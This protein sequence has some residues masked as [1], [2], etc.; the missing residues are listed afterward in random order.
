MSIKPLGNRVVIKRLAEEEKTHGGIIIP[1]V[2]QE[3]PGQGE[4][5]AAGCGLKDEHGKHIELDV[6]V[7]DVVVFH[8]RA[9]TEIKIEGKEYLILKETDIIGI[10]E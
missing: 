5:T 7:G 9:G 4:V 1:G 6:K 2:L 10:L 8:N 3:K